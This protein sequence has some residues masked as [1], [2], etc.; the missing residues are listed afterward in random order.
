MA[1]KLR[2]S[3]SEASLVGIDGAQGVRLTVSCGVASTEDSPDSSKQLVD[4]ADH[5]LLLAKNQ[6]RNRVVVYGSSGGEA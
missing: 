3:M 6:G 4:M 5:A 2:E 1:E